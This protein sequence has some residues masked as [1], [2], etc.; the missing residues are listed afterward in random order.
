M[1]SYGY[2]V[3]KTG[4][5]R[6]GKTLYLVERIVEGVP[7]NGIIEDRLSMYGRLEQDT[8]AEIY[9]NLRELIQYCKLNGRV[10]HVVD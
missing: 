10:C 4:K 7:I 9:T 2:R 8:D 3:T 6:K 1:A 5:R